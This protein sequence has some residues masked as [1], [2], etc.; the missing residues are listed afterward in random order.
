MSKNY[1]GNDE[2]IKVLRKKMSKVKNSLTYRIYNKRC[3]SYKYY[4]GDGVKMDERWNNDLDAFI[5]DV[6]SIPGYDEELF[7]SGKLALDKDY[8]GNSKKYDKDSCSWV[9]RED[10]NKNKPHQQKEFMVIDCATDTIIGIFLNQ[11]EVAR[12]LNTYQANISHALLKT[13]YY[14]RYIIRYTNQ[15]NV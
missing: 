6:T 2:H 1:R 15:L 13:G 14:K 10:N 3:P 4:G 12:L 7:L 5:E 8:L 9:S 11:S